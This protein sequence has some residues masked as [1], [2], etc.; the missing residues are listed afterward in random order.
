MAPTGR[1]P[2][3]ADPI[4][5]ALPSF[6]GSVQLSRANNDAGMRLFDAP[7]HKYTHTHACT[8]K[9]TPGSERADAR[10]RTPNEPAAR[11]HTYS[12]DRCPPSLP[13]SSTVGRSC[14]HHCR[15]RRSPLRHSL[16]LLS[17]WVG[18]SASR[19]PDAT[20]RFSLSSQASFSLHDGQAV[21]VAVAAVALA[22]FPHYLSGLSVQC[23]SAVGR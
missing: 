22:L 20:R 13:P 19:P 7:T 12:V 23:P 1:H 17:R 16:P 3:G 9:L 18:R 2:Q 21:T 10:V 8:L 5:E 4:L 14:G 11:P 6:S 15:A